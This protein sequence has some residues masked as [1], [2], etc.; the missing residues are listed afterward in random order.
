MDIK[1]LINLSPP[2]GLLLFLFVFGV[3]LKKA[4]FFHNRFIPVTQVVLGAVVYPL[5]S[6]S[7]P[8]G[9]YHPLA[10]QIFLG[11]LIGSGTVAGHQ[12]IKQFLAKRGFTLPGDTDLTRKDDE[13]R[14]KEGKSK[15]K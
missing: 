9:Y 2:A 8:V 14:W 5:L 3:V 1:E 15:V 11:A 13:T 7:I 6:N 10:T 4:A 12:V